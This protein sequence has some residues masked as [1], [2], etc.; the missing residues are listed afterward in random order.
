MTVH[1]Y[2]RY[3]YIGNTVASPAFLS[4]PHKWAK[5]AFGIALAN[6]LLSV[7]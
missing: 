5:V 3:V 7:S 4:L 1:L 6:F 2:C